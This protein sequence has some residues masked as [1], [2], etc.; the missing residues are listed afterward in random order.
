MSACTTHHDASANKM[1][2]ETEIMLVI[3]FPHLSSWKLEPGIVK[4]ML[5]NG[6]PVLFQM[7]CL[8]FFKSCNFHGAP[9]TDILLCQIYLERQRFHI[10]SHE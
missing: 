1:N 7:S 9:V 6:Y 4:K 2:F 5:K 10:K 3:P 8:S